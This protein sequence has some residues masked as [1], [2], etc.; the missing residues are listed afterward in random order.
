ME[1]FIITA[2]AIMFLDCPQSSSSQISVQEVTGSVPGEPN[3]QQNK[4]WQR[5][6]LQVYV[7]KLVANTKKM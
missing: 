4:K 6:I 2:Y 1:L 3:S 5:I 7:S